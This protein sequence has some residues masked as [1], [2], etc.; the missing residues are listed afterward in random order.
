MANPFKYFV[1]YIA[2]SDAAA[3]LAM[4]VPTKVVARNRSGFWRKVKTCFAP[5]F[6][7]FIQ[8]SN[9]IRLTEVRAISA[10][11]KKAE[12]Q[13]AIKRKTALTGRHLLSQYFYSA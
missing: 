7:R 8:I 10:P 3:T 9:V 12:E 6:P 2:I 13:K 11:E 1:R 4:F 5:F